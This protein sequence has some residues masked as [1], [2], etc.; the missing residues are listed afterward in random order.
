MHR[1]LLTLLVCL[2]TLYSFGQIGE[3]ANEVLSKRDF[4]AFKNLADDE[5]II[6]KYTRDLVEG[7][8]E[9]VFYIHK[10]WRGCTELFQDPKIGIITQGNLIIC[11]SFLSNNWLNDDHSDSL[12]FTTYSYTDTASVSALKVR[13]QK[14][15]LAPVNE[16]ELFKDDI[17]YGTKCNWDG[18]ITEQQEQIKNWVIKRDTVNLFTWLQS[19]NTEKQIYAVQGF[20]S[21]HFMGVKISDNAKR[22]I[23]YII[24]KKGAIKTCWLDDHISYRFVKYKWVSISDV[25]KDFNFSTPMVTDNNRR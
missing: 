14:C 17:W 9:S 2:L 19:T 1:I 10:S 21:L 22:L 4:N 3:K 20:N 23:S 13:F 16:N 11:Y 8:Q 6:F 18:K 5:K 15:F 24:K 7:Y 25:V 12:K